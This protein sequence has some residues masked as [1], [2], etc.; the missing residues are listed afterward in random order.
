MGLPAW[1]LGWPGEPAP[2]PLSATAVTAGSTAWQADVSLCE[3]LSEGYP[4]C[5][6]LSPAGS[7]E[8]YYRLSLPW[9]FACKTPMLSSN[10]IDLMLSDAK[11]HSLSC[12][13]VSSILF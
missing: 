6:P 3:L 1:V 9:E 12:S 5:Q 13:E 7:G 4:S 8:D 10:C 11:M 2:A